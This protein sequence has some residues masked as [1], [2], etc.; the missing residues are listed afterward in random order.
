MNNEQ[1]AKWMVILPW[2][3]YHNL[4]SS[5]IGVVQMPVPLQ[6]NPFDI[7]LQA[8]DACYGP[9][10]IP[11]SAELQKAFKDLC[12]ADW[13]PNQDFEERKKNALKAVEAKKIIDKYPL[14][15]VYVEV[16]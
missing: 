2:S 13:S 12:Y 8:N 16:E 11:E 10:C 14:F 9:L 6:G 7:A 1:K 4:A 3:E 5:P 15:P